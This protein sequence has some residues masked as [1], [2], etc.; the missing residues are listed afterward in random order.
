MAAEEYMTLTEAQEM[1]GISRFKM[2]QLVREGRV[3]LYQNEL[4]RREKLVRVA[5][6]EPLRQPRRLEPAKKLAA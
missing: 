5:D 6:L 1:L 2:A 4:D 3:T